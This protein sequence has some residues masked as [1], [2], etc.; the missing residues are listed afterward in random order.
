MRG[1]MFGLYALSGKA[2]AFMGP[3]VLGTVTYWTNSQRLGMA[4]VL[5]F[6]V[7]GGTLLAL[8]RHPNLR[9]A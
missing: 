8:M 7:V 4:T 9:T 5:A 2:T 6:F 1:E 3:F